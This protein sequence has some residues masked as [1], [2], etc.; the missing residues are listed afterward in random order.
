MEAMT[1]KLFK[2]GQSQA[3]RIPKP[4]QFTGTSEV[5]ICRQG[6]SVIITPKRKSWLS[7]ADSEPVDDG[8]MDSRP[9]LFDTGRVKF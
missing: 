8:F 4:F 6:S 2:N 3:V 7:L 1:V 9:D 5:T